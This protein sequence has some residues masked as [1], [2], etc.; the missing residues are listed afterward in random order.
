ML[1]PFV[2]ALMK[3]LVL[4]YYRVSFALFAAA[5]TLGLMLETGPIALGPGS[6]YG[7]TH[8]S[9]DIYAVFFASPQFH[10]GAIYRVMEPS[11]REDGM[12]RFIQHG[13]VLGNEF[14]TESIFRN[15]WTVGQYECFLSY[16]E[17][18]YVVIEQ[19]YVN[20]DHTNEKSLLDSFV[21]SGLAG[22]TYTDPAGRFTVY[23][24][25]ALSARHRVQRHSIVAASNE[26]ACVLPPVQRLGQLL[27]CSLARARWATC[28]LTSVSWTLANILP[29]FSDR[30]A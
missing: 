20:S 1:T 4:R 6:Y 9:S 28:A 10:P 16:K 19:A 23:D 2:L 27:S 5:L 18:R 12:Y 11:A 21:T 25:Q 8:Q 22:I 24:V 13:A 14:F 26:N 30:R 3:P 29:F 15:N 17:V 7:V